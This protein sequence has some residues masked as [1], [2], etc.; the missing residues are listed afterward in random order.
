QV[1]ALAGGSG[2]GKSTAAA[3]LCRLYEPLE[4]RVTLDGVDLATLKPSWLR[5]AVGVVEQEPVLF[6]GTV[7]ENIRFGRPNATDADVVRAAKEANCHDFVSA[8]PLGYDT[9][10]G[11]HGRLLS[12]GQRQRVAIA[13]AILKD[14]P[15]L[16]LDEATSALTQRSERLVAEALERA[17]WGRTVL[18]IAHRLSTVRRADVVAVLEGGR[19]TEMGSFDEL[20][21]KPEGTLQKLMDG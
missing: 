19:I 13:R 14:P 7:G 3:L 21:A 16:I 1:V 15:L 11:E 17:M 9:P 10:V 20:M 12:G 6:S 4:G 18:V 8:F 2:A 5:S